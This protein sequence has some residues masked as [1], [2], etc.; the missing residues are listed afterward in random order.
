[1]LPRAPEPRIGE[2]TKARPVA[3]DKPMSAALSLFQILIAEDNGVGLGLVASRL[4]RVN[5]EFPVTRDGVQAIVFI[6]GLEGPPQR[7][8]KRLNSGESGE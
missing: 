2:D 4:P 6:D 8:N 1:M 3:T 7:L 5:R